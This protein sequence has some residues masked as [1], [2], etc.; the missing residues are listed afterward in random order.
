[1]TKEQIVQMLADSE[2]IMN[3]EKL[4]ANI[5]I[6]SWTPITRDDVLTMVYCINSYDE[7]MQKILEDLD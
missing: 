5:S 7:I 3:Y 2:G 1:M 4:R 6:K